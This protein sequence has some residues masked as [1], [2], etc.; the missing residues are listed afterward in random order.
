MQMDEQNLPWNTAGFAV[1]AAS[2]LCA[3]DIILFNRPYAS[4]LLS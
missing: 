1:I 2:Y 3:P 4:V